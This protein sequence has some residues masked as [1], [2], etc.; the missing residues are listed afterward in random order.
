MNAVGL[1]SSVPGSGPAVGKRATVPVTCML[2]PSVAVEGTRPVPVWTKM[3]SGSAGVA[4][5]IDIARLQVEAV[6]CNAGDDSGSHHRLTNVRCGAGNIAL[7]GVDR[8]Q[9]YRSKN[10]D[11]NA[12]RR[13]AG[14]R[15][16]PCRPRRLDCSY[17]SRAGGHSQRVAIGAVVGR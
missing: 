11:G 16:A 9:S 5:G 14:L 1:S 10:G 15:V 2:V 13:S 4:V 3:P 6:R 8:D 17:E 7:D 12:A